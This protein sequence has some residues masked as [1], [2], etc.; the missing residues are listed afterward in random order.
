MYTINKTPEKSLKEHKTEIT[1]EE[2]REGDPD[3]QFPERSCFIVDDS[4]FR[5]FLMEE[6]N[7]DKNT[8]P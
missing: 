8:G 2:L 5:D 4:H 6:A 7:S 3:L 1:D